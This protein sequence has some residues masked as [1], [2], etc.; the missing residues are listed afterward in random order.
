MLNTQQ[1]CQILA[2]N[3]NSSFEDIK[4]SY[5]KMV[6]ELHPDRNKNASDVKFKKITEAY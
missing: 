3:D 2:L 6:L 5:R 1:A 4:Y